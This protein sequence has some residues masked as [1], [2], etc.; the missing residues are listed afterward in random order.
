[1]CR[2]T[3]AETARGH[4]SASA[5]WLPRRRRRGR[6]WWRAPSSWQSES[7][8]ETS[9]DVSALPLCLVERM[10]GTLDQVGHTPGLVRKATHTKPR[11]QG[12]VLEGVALDDRAHPL[13]V[14]EC[15]RFG[16]ARQQGDELIAAVSGDDGITARLAGQELDDL[17]EDVV[18]RV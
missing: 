17:L 15:R 3:R 9:N 6:S 16:R 8:H 7:F 10:V 1:P 2:R 14:H 12:A 11:G 18:A 4:P 5:R 13:G